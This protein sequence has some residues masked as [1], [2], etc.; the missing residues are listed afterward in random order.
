M[1]SLYK[2]G[3][4]H[5]IRDVNCE[6]K[7]FHVDDLDYALSQGYKTNPKDLYSPTKEEADTNNSGKLS[8]KE[9]REAAKLAGI[10]NYSKK[11]ITDLLS[12]LGYEN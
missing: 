5:I 1:I 7:Q 11:K 10:K 12:E 4:T 3:N 8:T 9:I 6:L 2:E